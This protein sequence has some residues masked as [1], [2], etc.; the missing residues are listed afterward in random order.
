M[1]KRFAINGAIKNKEDIYWLIED[2]VNELASL[3]EKNEILPDY[4]ARVPERKA[5]WNE[6]K[7]L[8]P[9][10]MLPENSRWA[11]MLPWN[12]ANL[13][14]D[15]LTGVAGSTGKVTGTA[16]VLYGPEDFHKM[17]HGDVL[18]AVTTTPAWTPLFAMASAIVSDLGG[19]L[20]HS[21]IV[22]REYGIPAVVSTGIATRRIKDGQTITVDGS[23]GRVE[24]KEKIHDTQIS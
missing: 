11:K 14:S 3:L 10:A 5:E 24:L 7:K 4:S 21:S 17:K 22:A 18:V 6:Q 12:R 15:V 8:I 23:A 16:R 13:T 1:G 2:E 19:P 9:P 20:S